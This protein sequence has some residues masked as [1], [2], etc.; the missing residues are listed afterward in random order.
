MIREVPLSL[1]PPL[2][3]AIEPML[4]AALE[5]HP[6]MDAEGIRQRIL[7]GAAEIILVLDEAKIAGVIAMEVIA[8]PQH[9]VGNILALAGKD[10]S[11]AQFDDE[12]EAFLVQW[13]RERSLDSLAMLGR[14]G[15]S[16][17]L[18]MRGWRTQLMCTAWKN[19]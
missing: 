5:Y 19:L 8:Y 2:W 12:V 7:A 13:C 16:K 15:W 6:F 1:L 17:V 11:M 9:R 3:S 4:T 14:P 10:G 18:E